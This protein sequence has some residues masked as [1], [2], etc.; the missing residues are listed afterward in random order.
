MSAATGFGIGTVFSLGSSG[1][2][3]L[4]VAR[5]AGE[6]LEASTSRA[7][8]AADAQFNSIV[9]GGIDHFL[10]GV[11]GVTNEWTRPGGST[12]LSETAEAFGTGFLGGAQGPTIGA[13]RVP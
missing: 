12:E 1:L 8:S 7:L 3:S 13:H 4:A 9:T 10:G 6:L 2:S 5:P 11:G